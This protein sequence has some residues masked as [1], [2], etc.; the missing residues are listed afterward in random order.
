MIVLVACG[1]N[2]LA[3]DPIR[4]QINSIRVLEMSAMSAT[5]MKPSPRENAR[6]GRWQR[7]LAAYSNQ[8]T[9]QSSHVGQSILP[10]LS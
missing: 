4:E 6:S 3:P 5:V 2:D 8:A 7:C 9:E 10:G 1:F